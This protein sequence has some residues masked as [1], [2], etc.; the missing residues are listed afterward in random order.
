MGEFSKQD[1]GSN[2]NLEPESSPE[3]EWFRG[4]ASTAGG[5]GS[6]P[7]QGIKI[8]YAAQRSH[9]KENKLKPGCGGKRRMDQAEENVGGL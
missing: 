2:Q 3:V 8:L 5:M 1:E 9:K 7:G 4:C 6:V